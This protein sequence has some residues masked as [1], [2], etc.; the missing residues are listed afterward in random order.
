MSAGGELDE[1]RGGARKVPEEVV[2]V[3]STDRWV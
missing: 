3:I 1:D 2:V